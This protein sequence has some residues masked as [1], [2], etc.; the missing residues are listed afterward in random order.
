MESTVISV[1]I[2]KDLKA[3]LDKE[4]IDIEQSIKDFLIQKAA[5]VQLREEVARLKVLITTKVKPSKKG[6]AV[7]SV[8]EDRYVAR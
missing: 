4:G 7:R 6:F 5:M 8:R 1:R 3:K 2:K